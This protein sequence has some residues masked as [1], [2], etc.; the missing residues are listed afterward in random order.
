MFTLSFDRRHKVLMAR[1]TGVFSSDDITALD[2]KIVR[3]VSRE[4]E[5]RGIL[6]FTAVEALAVS[7]SRLAVRGRQ[8]PVLGASDRVFV[9]PQPDINRFCRSFAEHQRGSGNVGPKLVTTLGEAYT[10]L[11]LVNPQFEPVDDG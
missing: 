9:A 3:V 7:A 6:D 4:G 8:P 10:A 2:A 5:L 1:A 11:G